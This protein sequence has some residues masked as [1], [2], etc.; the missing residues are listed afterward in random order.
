MTHPDPRATRRDASNEPTPGFWFEWEVRYLPVLGVDFALWGGLTGR[1]ASGE[2]T[3]QNNNA[4]KYAKVRKTS[5]KLLPCNI[6]HFDHFFDML[7]MHSCRMS[8][9]RSLWQLPASKKV[10]ETQ[11]QAETIQMLILSVC[12]RYTP[13]NIYHQPL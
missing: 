7:L 13:R 8:G 4:A 12:Q 10:A 6:L 9:G 2:A 1:L 3:T 5:T 11:M